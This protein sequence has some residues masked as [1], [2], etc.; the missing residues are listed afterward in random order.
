MSF[1]FYPIGSLWDG[2]GCGPADTC[3]FLNYGSC[4]SFHLSQLVDIEMRMCRDQLFVLDTSDIDE[5]TPIEVIQLYIHHNIA[6]WDI[7]CTLLA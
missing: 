1:T 4:S 5:D 7:L 3:C 6:D 2:A